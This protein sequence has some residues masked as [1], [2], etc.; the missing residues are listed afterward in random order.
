MQSSINYS[1]TLSMKRNRSTVILVISIFLL[2]ILLFYAS[3]LNK[4]P[5]PA[6]HHPQH[7]LPR[8]RRSL[9]YFNED[10][11]NH[12]I[13]SLSFQDR[14][15]RSETIRRDLSNNGFI[16][17]SHLEAIPFEEDNNDT[18]NTRKMKIA[19]AITVTRDGPYLDGAAIL[20][21]SMVMTKSRHDI[22]FV[23]I[24]H[25]EVQTTRPALKALGFKIIEYLPPILSSDIRG[26]HLRESI[27][28]SGC[29][30]ALELLK[31]RAYQ[32]VQYDR[33]LVMDMDA[34]FLKNIDHLFESVSIGKHLL[35]T[36]DEAMDNPGS[37][38]APVQGGFLLMTPSHKVYNE[39]VE[40]LREG[41]FRPGSA[42]GGT[43]IGWCWGGATVQ[44]I[45][46]YYFNIIAPKDASVV[47]DLC[48]YNAMVGTKPCMKTP[49]SDIYSVHFTLCQKPWECHKGDFRPLC[50]E[51][52]TA[53]W[54]IRADFEKTH[55]FP[56]TPRC[57]QD[58][59]ICPTKKYQ[60]LPIS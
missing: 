28:G 43:D 16:T 9:I 10:N 56:V 35:Y 17:N 8:F 26:R 32:L 58:K 57:C 2:L 50:A 18:S 53:W 39:L 12:Q 20:Q 34:I 27:D 6:P 51:F 36:E 38:A 37:K 44:G 30:G 25:K 46:A 5:L 3:S 45:L 15:Q 49:F 55:G 13:Q 1:S 11:K 24:V 14:R 7:N 48:T 60:T 4:L 40:I 59:S 31:I 33:V 42:W 23:A 29:C 41:D 19:I 21:H 52:H 22:E 47:L 54:S